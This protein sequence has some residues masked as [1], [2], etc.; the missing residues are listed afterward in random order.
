VIVK[1]HLD[2]EAVTSDLSIGHV[3]EYQVIDG[4]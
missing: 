2:E 1:K 3:E 4:G